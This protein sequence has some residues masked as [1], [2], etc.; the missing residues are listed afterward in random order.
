MSA[1]WPATLPQLPDVDWREQADPQWTEFQTD[2]GFSKRRRRVTRE[3]RMRQVR[4]G[5][6]SGTQLATFRTFYNTT[7]NGG[8]DEFTV[9][10]GDPVAGTTVTY[11][12]VEPPRVMQWVPSS[13]AA[14]RR[15]LLD[16]ILEV[17]SV[18]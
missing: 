3:R 1:V 9:T 7:I 8:T 6:L 4:F 2:A 17:V 5:D 14:S 10:N 11:R 18:A 16:A 12:F 15:Y 13:T